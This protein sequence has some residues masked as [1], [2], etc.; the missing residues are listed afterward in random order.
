MKKAIFFILI[1][2]L[3]F[4][5]K[6]KNYRIIRTESNQD[7]LILSVLWYQRS[8][9]MQAL[10]YQGYNI[11]R[12]SLD[13]KLKQSDNRRPK[14]IIMDIDET[15]LDSSPVE[16]S[17]V[18]N[19]VTFSDSLWLAWIKKESAEPLPGAL[20]FTRFA[21]SKG[22][23]VFYITNRKSR[24]ESESTINNLRQKG[25]PF[26]DSLHVIMRKDI[27]S[28]ETRRKAVAENYNI[29]LLLGDNL[30]DFDVIFD[31]RGDDL[32]FMAVGKNKEKFG[33]RFILFPNPMYGSW[34]NAAISSAP[35]KTA[36]EKFF[37]TLKSF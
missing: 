31:N 21:E 9:E 34:L 20:D 2:P 30:A 32:G 29:L 22:V 14:A 37:Q 15:V 36:R 27:S 26:A 23:E 3:L 19:N 33:S 35:G 7:Q 28:K 18:I 8:A 4:S 25:Y 13:E 6:D 12:L 24:V 1:F 17:Q 5:C 11:A 10:Y 16:A